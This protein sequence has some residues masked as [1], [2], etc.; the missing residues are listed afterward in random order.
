MPGQAHGLG[1]W[2][3]TAADGPGIGKHF[4]RFDIE[5][6]ADLIEEVAFHPDTGAKIAGFKFPYWDEMLATVIAGAKVFD[7]L[8]TLGWD[9]ALTEDGPVLL[10]ANWRYDSDGL[11]LV[12]DMGLKDKFIQLL[13]T[14]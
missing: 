1:M 7:N 12:L 14:S 2:C 6:E 10:E 4:L 5:R 3:Q 8:Y 13:S 11:Q 9:V